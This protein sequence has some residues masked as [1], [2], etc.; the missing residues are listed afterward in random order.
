[1]GLAI[2]VG[3]FVSRII[4]AIIFY[5]LLTPIGLLS[6]LFGRDPLNQK[7]DKGRQTYWIKYSRPYDAK[8]FEQM[9]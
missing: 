9:Y 3:F 2:A 8:D 7:I 4:L 5:L 1:M 6:R